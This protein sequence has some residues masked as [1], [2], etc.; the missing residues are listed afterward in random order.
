MHSLRILASLESKI[1][2]EMGDV[3]G[4]VIL[5]RGAVANGVNITKRG[6]IES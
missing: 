1:A 5:D 4:N 6:A 3:I 2:Q